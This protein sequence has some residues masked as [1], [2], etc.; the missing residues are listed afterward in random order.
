MAEED[1]LLVRSDPKR[2]RHFGNTD[3]SRRRRFTEPDRI[4]LDSPPTTVH[5]RTNCA[6][7][8]FLRIGGGGLDSRWYCASVGT[9]LRFPE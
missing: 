8:R 5:G 3:F 2:L 4:R 7:R 6:E 1:S 9:V